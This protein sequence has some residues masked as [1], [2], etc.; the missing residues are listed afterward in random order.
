MQTTASGTQ[1]EILHVESES[2]IDTDE[3]LD[4]I[5]TTPDKYIVSNVMEMSNSSGIDSDD[6]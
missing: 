1:T 6:H 4:T 3:C 2:Q 5:I